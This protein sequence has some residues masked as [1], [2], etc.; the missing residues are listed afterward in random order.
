[1]G[2]RPAPLVRDMPNDSIEMN[3]KKD[4]GDER[5]QFLRTCGCAL[6]GFAVSGIVGGCEFSHIQEPGKPAT[7][8][9]TV[10]IDV[11]GLTDDGTGLLSEL[12]G[13]DRRRIFVARLG[14]AT[15]KA[16]STTCTHSQ[17]PLAYDAPARKLWCTGGQ[18]HG[19]TFDIEGRPQTGPAVPFGPVVVY[20][21]EFIAA[22]KV[23]VVTV[24]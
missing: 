8:G 2:E 11:S 16:L 21:S 4:P 5:R 18:G 10:E 12:R 19:S 22:R 24:G 20:P 17:F 6:A 1:M 13:P 7:G 15:Y 9:K 14:E 3:A 23:L